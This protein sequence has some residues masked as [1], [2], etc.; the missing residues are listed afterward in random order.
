MNRCPSQRPKC[1]EWHERDRNLEDAAAVTRLTISRESPYPALRNIGCKRGSERDFLDHQIHD[2]CCGISLD[3]SG[4]CNVSNSA[5]S[6][7]NASPKRESDINHEME[8]FEIAPRGNFVAKSTKPFASKSRSFS[9]SNQTWAPSVR[10]VA[11]LVLQLSSS[12]SSSPN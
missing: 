4:C 5:R 12:D 2:R 11:H 9:P 8:P 1:C 3:H 7:H 6:G 10:V